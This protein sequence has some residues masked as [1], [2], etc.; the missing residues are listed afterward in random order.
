MAT[1]CEG[2]EFPL[3]ILH[4]VDW[5]YGRR[6]HYYEPGAIPE[7]HRQ[8]IARGGLW[9]GEPDVFP[10]SGLN[11]GDEMAVSEGTPRNGVRTAVEDF[12]SEQGDRLELR[13]VVGLNG[14]GILF[15]KAQLE[16]NVRLRTCLDTF[17]STEWL[18][19]QCERLEQQRLLMQARFE[20]LS[21]KYGAVP[22]DWRPR[23]SSKVAPRPD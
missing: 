18:T 3:A 1:A 2:H 8:P 11:L 14:L 4:D 12:V 21:Q 10:D 13:S 22:A 7:E 23:P 17:E 20:T 5:P 16:A 6:D 9:P 15:S 19:A